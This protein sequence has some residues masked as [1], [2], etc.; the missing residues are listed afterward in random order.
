MDLTSPIVSPQW[1]HQHLNNA[2][3]S[4]LSTDLGDAIVIID[5]RFNLAQPDLGQQQYATAHIPGA[6]YLHLDHDLS[7]PVQAH[8]G[9]HPL[10]DSQQFAQKLANLGIDFNQTLVVAYDDSRF[11]F[12]ARLWWLLRYLGHDRVAVLD[13]GF[14]TWQGLGYPTDGEMPEQRSGQFTPQTRPEWLVTVQDVQTR[15][16]Q[17]GTILIDSR[18]PRRYRGEVEPIDPIAGHIPGAVNY[19]WQDITEA[20]G[21]AKTPKWHQQQWADVAQGSEIMVYCGSGVTACVNLLSLEV[22]GVKNAKLY[23]G[24]WSDWCSYPELPWAKGES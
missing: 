23:G 5:C 3:S 4:N 8:G 22:A 19:F 14:Q 10:P 18:D 13:G 15:K 21:Q 6:H 2:T 9:R 20:N 1:L 12:A 11:A 24:S 16:D 7:S 17:P